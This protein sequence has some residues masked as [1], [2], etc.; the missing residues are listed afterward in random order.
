MET[1][2]QSSGWQATSRRAA[3]ELRSSYDMLDAVGET[4][5]RSTVAGFLAQSLL[6]QGALDEASAFC[7]RS[8]EL[9]TEADIA[10]QALWRYVRGRILVRQGAPPEAELI[11]R[12]AIAL[13]EE[14]DAI[15]YKIEARVALGEALAAAGRTA[16]AREAYE[17]AKS[18]AEEKGGV[19]I[20]TGVL[21][22]LEVL[23]AART[24]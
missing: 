2:E 23:D 1:P 11:T 10:T 14:T 20:L 18:L 19:V 16:E 22:Q 13:L 21:R 15:V 12:E 9:T 8:R 4:Y 3:R 6:E 17:S 24:T 5:L 7:D